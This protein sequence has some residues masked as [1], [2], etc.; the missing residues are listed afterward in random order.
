MDC[1]T[2]FVGDSKM[3]TEPTIFIQNHQGMGD[4]LVA[5]AIF[6]HFAATHG[7]IIPCKTHNL[8]S[9]QFMLKDLKPAPA[10]LAVTNDEQVNRLLGIAAKRGV[11]ALRLGMFASSSFDEKHWDREFYRVAGIPFERRW[12]DWKVERDLSREFE[13]PK[14]PYVFI[15]EDPDRGFIIDRARLPDG[16]KVFA[17]GGPGGGPIFNWC[18]LIENAT[19]LHL[20]DSCFAILADSMTT[21][22]AKRKVIHLY[23]RPNALPPTYKPGW[24]IFK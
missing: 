1:A 3:R 10:F 8:P 11:K 2:T 21:L 4:M 15:H 17:S 12:T 20:I 19:E 5:N 13:P 6:R 23:S 7:V 9:V 24:E 16:A 18:S 22:K 14:E